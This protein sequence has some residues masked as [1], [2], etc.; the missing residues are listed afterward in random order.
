M[1]ALEIYQRVRSTKLTL[2]DIVI[3][4]II[5][6]NPDIT[7]GEIATIMGT[8]KGTVSPSVNKLVLAELVRETVHHLPKRHKTYR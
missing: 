8:T 5:K 1:T 7:Q 2:N 3:E 4:E 6:E